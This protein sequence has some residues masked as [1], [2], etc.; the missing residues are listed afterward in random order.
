MAY[1]NGDH[2]QHDQADDHGDLARSGD[3]A[4]HKLTGLVLAVRVAG[5]A[6]VVRESRAD[7]H[8]EH[9]HGAVA[10]ALRRQ[11]E[12]TQRAAAEQ[13][14]AP[15]DEHHAQQVP[16]VGA[17]GDGLQRKAEVELIHGKIA[18]E[19]DDKIAAKP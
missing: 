4:D 11:D 13:H 8:T 12:L 6:E 16:D 5:E 9:G 10:V 17:V 15:A 3:A 1:S 14:A 18:D 19:R 7:D 2:Q